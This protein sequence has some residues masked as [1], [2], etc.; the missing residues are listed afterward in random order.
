MVGAQKETNDTQAK[1]KTATSY[2]LGPLLFCLI[3]FGLGS[4]RLAFGTELDGCSHG[5]RESENCYE[6]TK[7]AQ[8]Q[9]IP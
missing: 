5:V 8:K 7:I 6:A 3:D 9:C 1:G 4:L 2:I